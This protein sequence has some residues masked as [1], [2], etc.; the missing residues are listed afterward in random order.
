MARH[1][2]GKNNYRLSGEALIALLVVLLL[3]AGLL[4]FIFGRGTDADEAQGGGECVAGDVTLPVAASDH[5]VAEQLMK[6]YQESAPVVRDHCVKPQLV[7]NVADAAVYLAPNTPVTQQQLANAKRTSAVSEPAIVANQPVGLAGTAE[8]KLDQVGLDK[9]RFA[10]SD[11]PS[12]SAVVAGTLAKGDDQAAVKALTDQR[13]DSLD[14]FDGADDTFVATSEVAVPEGLTFTPIDAAVSYAAIPLNAAGDVTEDQSRAGQD[15]ARF[16][17]DKFD[18]QDPQQPVIAEMV[19]AAALP[20]GGAALTDG[21]ANDGADAADSD[22]KASAKKDAPESESAAGPVQN[23]LFLL[24]TSDGMAPYIEPAKDA[25]GAAA[26][27]VGEQGKMVGLWNYSSPLNPGVTRGYRDNVAL[28]GNAGDVDQAVHRFLTGG[29]P[30]TR[31][32]VLAAAGAAAQWGDPVRIV[33][34]TTGTA[35]AGNDE[36][37]ANAV[38]PF[39]DQGVDVTV[40]H[41]GGEPQDQGLRNVASSDQH[42]DGAEGLTDAVKSAAGVK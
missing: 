28:T 16:S 17:A 23:T 10:A 8:A 34:V 7:D 20:E 22:A 33:V 35:D 1:S 32:A 37:F 2:N 5:A 6:T 18:G 41:V 4:W 24:D 38:R 14:G 11:E 26:G 27:A 42:V 13:V 29:V 12:A 39:T 19:W 9:V 30:Q 31:E 25:V 21:A 3:I 36:E 15:L 40:V